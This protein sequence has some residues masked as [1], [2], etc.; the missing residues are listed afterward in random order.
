MEPRKILKTKIHHN[1]KCRP[2]CESIVYFLPQEQ[3]I[4]HLKELLSEVGH[5]VSNGCGITPLSPVS[6]GDNQNG[7]T[8]DTTEPMETGNAEIKPSNS[9]SEQTSVNQG[10]DAGP[11]ESR[12]NEIME[13]DSSDDKP[14]IDSTAGPSHSNNSAS[15]PDKDGTHSSSSSSEGGN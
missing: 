8:S 9:L 6:T 1:M 13:T 3:L 7:S 14:D 5:K 2:C 15:V 4:S 12:C 11:S 10:N